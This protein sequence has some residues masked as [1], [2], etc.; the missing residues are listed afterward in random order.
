[1]TELTS[2]PL[3]LRR[4][5]VYFVGLDLGKNQDHS[6]LAVIERRE[7]VF[8]ERDHVTMEFRCEVRNVLR[9]LQ[10]VPLHTEQHWLSS[11]MPV[12]PSYIA[13]AC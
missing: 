6:S 1:M 3:G 7:L 11:P 10:R 12:K 8:P 5:P 9:H 2:T 4:H 13:S